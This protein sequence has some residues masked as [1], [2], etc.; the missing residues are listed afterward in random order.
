M[1]YFKERS[2]SFFASI[3]ELVI[4][5]LL[6]VNPYGFI[7]GI[8]KVLGI[9]LLVAG[10]WQII[11][12]FREAPE[13]AMR[14]TRLFWGL[15]LALLGL[16][17]LLRSGWFMHTLSILVVVIGI[18]LLVSG[19]MKVQWTID[20]A[21]VKAPR[22]G[23]TAASAILSVLIGLVFI[24]NPFSTQAIMWQVLAAFL[25]VEAVLDILSVVFGMSGR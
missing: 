24:F 9:V 4:G 18:V 12:H 23:A 6:W 7:S 20:L 3:V 19:L 22:W 1:I 8:V 21:R 2:N 10:I 5:I 11:E 25:I 14:G 13:F 17:C 15:I 16:F